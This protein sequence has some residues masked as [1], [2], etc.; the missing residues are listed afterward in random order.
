M[1]GDPEVVKKKKKRGVGGGRGRT[2]NMFRETVAEIFPYFGGINSQIQ[3]FSRLTDTK[4]S[5]SKSIMVKLLKIKVKEE[6]HESS[7]R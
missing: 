6:N 4:K 7:Q 5:V 1:T 2:E 3:K